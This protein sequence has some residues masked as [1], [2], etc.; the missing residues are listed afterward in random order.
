MFRIVLI[1]F[2]T[3]TISAG[4]EQNLRIVHVIWRH[5]AR[6]PLQLF[7]LDS[8]SKSSKWPNGLGELTSVARRCFVPGNGTLLFEIFKEGMQQQL[9]L[10]KLLHERYKG[11]LSNY[12]AKSVYVRSTDTNRTI[13]SAL[14]NLHGMFPS[15]GTDALLN[16]SWQPIP[17]HTVPRRFDKLLEVT[18]SYC[19]YPDSI[20][21]NEVMTSEPVKKIM[22][23]NA[24][25]FNFLR[26]QT[27]L[28][29]PTFTDIY[30]VYDPLNCETKWITVLIGPLLEDI[31]TLLMRK[32]NGTLDEQLKYVAYSAHETTLI[33]LLTNLDVY[34]VTMAPE[35]SACL[36]FEL[37]Q[38]NGTYYV[39]TWYLNGLKAE[40][41]M[42]NLPGCPTPC[43]VKTFAQMASGRAPQN[44]HDECRITDELVFTG[45]SS[46]AQ[47]IILVS[48]VIVAVIAVGAAVI[49]VFMCRC[50]KRQKTSM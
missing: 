47:A 14:V 13:V 1:T 36:M 42:L 26:N 19:P 29:I 49:V 28:A 44:W 33:A 3:Q 34:D 21:F 37:Y 35:F 15:K 46:N 10:G 11:F 25:L 32:A 48:S 4:V 41:V 43:D 38:E 50:F 31:A 24:E 27:G 40:S 18:S 39:E 16:V 30:D 20:F 6:A 45:L 8:V 12:T 5:G 9:L 17:V 22:E 23:E 2:L 7:P